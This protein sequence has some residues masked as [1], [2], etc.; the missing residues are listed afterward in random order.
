MRRRTVD[1]DHSDANARRL[2]RTVTDLVQSYIHMH[3]NRLIRSSQRLHE[4]V[5]YDLLRRYYEGQLAR[6]R[7]KRE[8]LA[9]ASRA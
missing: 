5:L 9:Y 1:A 6:G 8:K 4:L 3:V 2:S 7:Q